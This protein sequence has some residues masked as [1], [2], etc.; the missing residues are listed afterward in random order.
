MPDTVLSP[1]DFINLRDYIHKLCGLYIQESKQYLIVQRLEP[2][3]EEHGFADFDSFYRHLV[4]Q[5]NATLHQQIIAA[6]TTNETS[7]FRDG[8][9]F[10]AFKDCLLPTLGA[11]IKN[12]KRE[13]AK[14]GAPLETIKLWSAASS[15]GQEA[16][17]LAMLINEYA[18]CNQFL[19]VKL[20]DFYI[21]G[22]D[23]S[24]DALDR[25]MGGKFSEIEIGRGLPA[26]LLKKYFA[27][28]DREWVVRDDLRS[29][30]Q[31]RKMNLTERF[32]LLP[33]FDVILCRNVLIYFDDET[34][35]QILDRLYGQLTPNGVL[36]LGS[37]E[38]MYMMS[39]KFTS[40]V[41]GGTTIY[42][43]SATSASAS[44]PG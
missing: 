23:I 25:A 4:A 34:K 6:M 7:F 3:L 41:V 39:D 2:V 43:K 35:K 9:P 13:N 26:E 15:T 5:P 32:G 28:A 33:K 44:K 18:E 10:T 8:H 29:I 21:L 14:N 19:G 42:R 24:S 30:V 37:A 20:K 36:I 17:S 11:E 1:Q 40:E 31:F 12:R 16:Y 27:Q 38:N 22:T